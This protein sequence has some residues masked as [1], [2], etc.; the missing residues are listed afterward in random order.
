MFLTF[1]TI[2]FLWELGYHIIFDYSKCI[3]QDLRMRRELGTSLRVGRMFPVN[4]L[5]LPLVAPVSIAAA[6][7][8]SSILSLALWHARL[9]HVSSSRVQQLAFRGLLGSVST[10][11]FDYVSCQL[12]KQPALP[13]N[14]SESI[15]IDI[16]NL[17]HFDVWGP[18]FVSSIGG[19]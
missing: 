13:F 2:Y 10:K 19:S 15:S 16:F 11:N 18:S 9:G 5:R 12:G 17:I 3:V 4:N 14:T 8:V 7:T 1:L 6:T